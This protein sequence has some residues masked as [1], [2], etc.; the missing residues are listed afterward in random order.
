[1]DILSKQMADLG[2]LEIDY[3]Q[4]FYKHNQIGIGDLLISSDMYMFD[5]YDD[6][7]TINIEKLKNIDESKFTVL[8]TDGYAVQMSIEDDDPEDGWFEPT[9]R[10]FI[11][12]NNI[13]Y[14]EILVP[15][16]LVDKILSMGCKTK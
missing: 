4:E 14:K 5:G 12:K 16:F 1:M 8:K 10:I 7:V 3:S 6:N 2:W 11:K 9:G 15:D 13:S